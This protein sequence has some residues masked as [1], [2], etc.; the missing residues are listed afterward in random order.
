MDFCFW[1]CTDGNTV[2]CVQEGCL[3]SE[4][5]SSMWISAVPL[6]STC[7]SI[8]HVRMWKTLFA[9]LPKACWSSGGRPTLTPVHLKNVSELVALRIS[10]EKVQQHKMPCLFAVM[11][12]MGRV[13]LKQ[14][15]FFLLWCKPS[16]SWVWTLIYLCSCT[17]YGRKVSSL[18]CSEDATYW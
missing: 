16:L 11:E 10:S 18:C 8:F 4:R 17:L 7:T 13:S 9:Y 15:E 3:S 14:N 5:E 12:W 1:R 2:G 6:Y